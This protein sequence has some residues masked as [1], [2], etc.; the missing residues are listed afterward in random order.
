MKE[1]D[2]YEIVHKYLLHHGAT[3]EMYSGDVHGLDWN[4]DDYVEF[5]R[6]ISNLQKDNTT[7]NLKAKYEEKLG[8]DFNP[9]SW[10]NKYIYD[11]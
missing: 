2:L 1:I 11:M 5:A 7:I 3:I 9:W 4:E 8:K 6:Y 10:C